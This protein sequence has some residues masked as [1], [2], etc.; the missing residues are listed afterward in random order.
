M[1]ITNTLWLF[2]ILSLTACAQTPLKEEIPLIRV[3]IGI[4]YMIAD[5]SCDEVK[6]TSIPKRLEELEIAFEWSDED[7]SLLTVGPII[8]DVES[9]SAYSKMRQTYFLTIVCR[10]EVT[11]R[12][13]SEAILEG[14]NTDGG[15]GA[16]TDIPTVERYGKKFLQSLVL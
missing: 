14:L 6:N 13:D 4:G 10:D 11:T 16:I 7:D 9:G 3:P 2:A 12:I 15:W 8:E 5:I 1:R